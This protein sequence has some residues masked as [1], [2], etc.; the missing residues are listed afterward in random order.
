MFICSVRAS[1]VRFFSVVAICI[2]G[3]VLAVGLGGESVPTAAGGSIRFDGIEDEA[4]RRAFIEAQGYKLKEQTEKKESFS[5]PKE[6]DRVV[7]E[8]NEIQK[9][10]GLDLEKYKGKKVTRYTYEITNYKDAKTGVYA[11]LIV[12]RSRIIACDI[13]SEEGEGFV[14]PL[15]SI[16]S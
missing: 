1:T 12:Y 4:A 13:S 14:L 8:Y 7:S 9:K 2:L 3:L 16:F 11:N 15:V 10:Q 6:F 5:V